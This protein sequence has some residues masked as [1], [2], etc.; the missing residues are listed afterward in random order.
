MLTDPNCILLGKDRPPKVTEI[1]GGRRNKEEGKDL[2]SYSA[3]D[4]SQD[5]I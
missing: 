3:E 4:Q 2:S 1:Q 5:A